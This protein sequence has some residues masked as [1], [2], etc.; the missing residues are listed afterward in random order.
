MA[1][2]SFAC[3]GVSHGCSNLLDL[4]HHQLAADQLVA[5]VQV[6][7]LADRDAPLAIHQQPRSQNA[8]AFMVQMVHLIHPVCQHLQ[9]AD[10]TA[11]RIFLADCTDMQLCGNAPSRALHAIQS[12]A[13]GHLCCFV[14]VLP[15]ALFT[16]MHSPAWLQW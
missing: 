4:H 15:P 2:S 12:Q 9:S 8:P 10:Q 3:F 13:A 7:V 1:W 5:N 11:N 16:S 14:L 6:C